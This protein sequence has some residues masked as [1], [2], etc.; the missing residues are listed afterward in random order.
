MEIRIRK[1]T[2]KELE[3]IQKLNLMLF[4][5]EHKEYDSTLNLEW[6]F[7]NEGKKYFSGIIKKGF[8]AVAEVE[9]QVVGYIVG[10]KSKNYPYRTTTDIAEL[11]NMLV[12]DKYRGHGIGR[13][14]VEAFM[15]W[16]KEKGYKHIKVEASAQNLGAIDFYRKLGF[17]DY[18]LI[19]EINPANK[20]V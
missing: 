10:Q 4:E 20:R 16:C 8:S 9:G 14:L 15:A 6:T 2:V 5:K 13:K 19:L 3:V 11:S 7:G 1:A 12:M 18:T 17:K